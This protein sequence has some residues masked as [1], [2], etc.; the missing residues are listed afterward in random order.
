MASPPNWL[1]QNKF[2]A[3]TPTKHKSGD[4]EFTVT[5]KRRELLEHDSKLAD[6]E[7]VVIG[8]RWFS[9]E[10]EVHKVFLD[11]DVEHVYK[12]SQTE[13]HGHLL[14]NVNLTR[15]ELE[16]LTEILVELGITGRGNLKQIQ[17]A[18]QLFLRW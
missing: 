14:L 7:E 18:E 17:E 10:H 6:G 4:A 8:S 3:I 13:D 15:K 1:S 12:P 16:T 5:D 2:F 11:I 9:G